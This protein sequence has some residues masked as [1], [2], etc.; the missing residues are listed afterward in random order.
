MYIRLM[1]CEHG[2]AHGNTPYFYNGQTHA[3]R[4]K[5]CCCCC[6]ICMDIVN[7]FKSCAH[8]VR[9]DF[10]LMRTICTKANMNTQHYINMSLNNIWKDFLTTTMISFVFKFFF[11][12][13]NMWNVWH[14]Q[15]AHCQ[16]LLLNFSV[17]LK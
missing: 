1:L 17:V 2:M 8:F 7:I 3:F 13:Y 15:L 9:V 4:C 16:F 6:S 11:C 5:S 14:V 12:K 10:N